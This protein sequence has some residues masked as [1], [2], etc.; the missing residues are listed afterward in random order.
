MDRTRSDSEAM[1][2]Y[3][4]HEENMAMAN[5]LSGHRADERGSRQSRGTLTISAASRGSRR[6]AR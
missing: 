6:A 5:T 3:A 2:E 4:C 1:I